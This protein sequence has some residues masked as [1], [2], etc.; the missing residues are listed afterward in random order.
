MFLPREHLLSL[1]SVGP[2]KNSGR[3][4]HTSPGHNPPATSGEEDQERPDHHGQNRCDQQDK[5]PISPLRVDRGRTEGHSSPPVC[6]SETGLRGGRLSRCWADCNTDGRHQDRANDNGTRS[7]GRPSWMPKE[8]LE[9]K[10][11]H[12]HADRRQEEVDHLRDDVESSAAYYGHDPRG[13]P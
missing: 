2:W 9:T 10:P 12:H 4:A 13:G 11:D 3:A 6:T 7:S 1:R 8:R 5:G